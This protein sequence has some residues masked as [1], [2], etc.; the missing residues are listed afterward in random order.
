MSGEALK[1]CIHEVW[2]VYKWDAAIVGE[3]P[4]DPTQIDAAAHPGCIEIL[5]IL[6]GQPAKCIHR[7]D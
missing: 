1:L 3:N 6:P 4:P 2:H 7:R 5:E